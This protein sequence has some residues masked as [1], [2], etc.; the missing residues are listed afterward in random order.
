MALPLLPPEHI[1]SVFNHTKTTTST[2]QLE[3]LY[4]YVQTTWIKGKVWT[5]LDGSVYSLA[6]R[7][8]NNVDGWHTRLNHRNRRGKY[9]LKKK[10]Q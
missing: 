3:K 5:P 6:I 8:N 9:Q 1:R 4:N 7:T 2:E 10:Y